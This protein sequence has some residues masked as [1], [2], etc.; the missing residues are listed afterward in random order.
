MAANKIQRPF[1][2]GFDAGEVIYDMYE[3]RKVTVKDSNNARRECLCSVSY[4]NE[5]GDEVPA[6][7]QIF[8]FQELVNMEMTQY[9]HC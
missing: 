2:K 8:T 1:Y 9:S 6:D 5:D 7:D 3:G 4:E